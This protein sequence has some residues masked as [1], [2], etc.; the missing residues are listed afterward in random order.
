MFTVARYAKPL[1]SLVIPSQTVATGHRHDHHL[2][3][4]PLCSSAVRVIDNAPDDLCRGR[5]PRQTSLGDTSY[6]V[7]MTPKPPAGGEEERSGAAESLCVGEGAA[8]DGGKASEA[9]NKPGSSMPEQGV[10]PRER[11]EYSAEETAA[12]LV[13]QRHYRGYMT[14]KNV[15]RMKM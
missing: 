11:A 1:I 8:R 7:D 13:I 2:L 5:P 14:R 12:A 4:P 10:S 6:F 9:T 15:K 3:H